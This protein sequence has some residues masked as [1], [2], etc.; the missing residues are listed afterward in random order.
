MRLNWQETLY[1]LAVQV[2]FALGGGVIFGYGGYLV[3][4]DQFLRPVPNGLT[5]GDL[6]VFMAYLAQFWDPLGWVLG[7]TTKIQTFVASCDRVFAVIDEPP[8]IADQ[9]DPRSR[10]NSKFAHSKY[11]LRARCANKKR[12]RLRRELS[13]SSEPSPNS[14][15]IQAP[16]ARL[17]KI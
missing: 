3:Y 11:P 14:E 5:I 1:P 6:I 17:W 4:H 13:G 12:K 15:P 9:P 16:N 10:S 2:I 7:F 8:A